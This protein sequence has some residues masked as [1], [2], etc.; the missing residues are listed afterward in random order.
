MDRKVRL[1]MLDGCRCPRI[2]H[3]SNVG[4]EVVGV[5]PSRR[6]RQSPGARSRPATDIP[7]DRLTGCRVLARVRVRELRRGYVEG[8]TSTRLAEIGCEGRR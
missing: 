2:L 3:C 5:F 4:R 8:W 7:D 6:L 1:K